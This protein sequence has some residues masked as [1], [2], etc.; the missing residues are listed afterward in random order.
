MVRSSFVQASF[1]LRL[2][3]KIY[4][5]D[6]FPFLSSDAWSFYF[7]PSPKTSIL[8]FPRNDNADSNAADNNL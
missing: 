7:D 3:K 5:N 6:G 1:A 4:G 2:L 8:L